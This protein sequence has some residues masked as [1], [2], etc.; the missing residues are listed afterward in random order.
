MTATATKDQVRKGDFLTISKSRRF[1]HI[2]EKIREIA[3]TRDQNISMVGN[4]MWEKALR[5]SGYIL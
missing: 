4:L 3:K 5:D 1:D 2:H